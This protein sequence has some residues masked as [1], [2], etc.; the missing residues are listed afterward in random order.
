[1]NN[2]GRKLVLVTLGTFSR[3]SELTLS[4]QR[5]LFFS[6]HH[7]LFHKLL[8]EMGRNIRRNDFW[9]HLVGQVLAMI[10]KWLPW[11][12]STNDNWGC[13]TQTI[14]EFTEPKA[15]THSSKSFWRRQFRFASGR[16]RRDPF[17]LFV[18][19]LARLSRSFASNGN[20]CATVLDPV[21]R[22]PISANPGQ[23][24]NF[25]PGFYFFFQKHIPG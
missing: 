15:C 23:G 12:Q 20:A 21:V 8:E 24:L 22:R 17:S 11:I 16:K 7:S 6:L 3:F 2:V 5:M 9:D 18:F 4:F 14:P 25:N 1:M 10:G 13:S 19:C